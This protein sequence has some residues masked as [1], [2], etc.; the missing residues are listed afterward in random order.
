MQAEAQLLKKRVPICGVLSV[1]APVLGFATARFVDVAVVRHAPPGAGFELIAYIALP[2]IGSLIC[3]M[4]LAGAAAFRDEKYFALRW[5][6]FLV[7][8]GPLFFLIIASHL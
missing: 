2:L 8:A 6:G 1:T 3:G 7:N 5:I 4:L